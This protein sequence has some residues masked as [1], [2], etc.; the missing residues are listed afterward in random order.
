MLGSTR[1]VE[2]NLIDILVV[3]TFQAVTLDRLE[4]IVYSITC[5]LLTVKCVKKICLFGILLLSL[6][7]CPVFLVECFLIT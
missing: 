1:Y 6:I 4:L 5:Y 3:T 2:G 7:S